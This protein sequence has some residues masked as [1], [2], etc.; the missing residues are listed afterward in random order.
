M[1]T[2]DRKALIARELARV[3]GRPPNPD[4][5]LGKHRKMAANPFRFLRGAAQ[6]FYADLAQGRLVL[7]P[8]LLE[9]PLTFIQGDCHFSNFGFLTEEGS[10]GDTVIWAPN[11][12]DDAAAGHAAFDL[13]RFSVSIHLIGDFCRGV[14]EGRYEVEDAAIHE[15]RPAPQAGDERAAVEAFLAEYRQ[16]CTAMQADSGERDRALSRFPKEHVLRKPGRKA[17]KR[18]AGGPDFAT[19]STVAKNTVLTEDRPRFKNRVDRFRALDLSLTVGVAEAFRPYVDDDIIDVVRRIGAGTGSVNVDRYYLLVGPAGGISERDLRLAHIVEV[20]QQREAALIHHF[21]ALS[22]VNTLSPAHLTVDCQRQMMR[23]P[24]LILDE[25][26][27]NR[28]HWL[29]RSRHHARVSLDPEAL[30][31][32]EAPGEALVQYATACAESLAR[33]HARGDRRSTRFEAA[34]AGAL[35]TSAEALADTAQAYAEQSRHDQKLLRLMLGL[36]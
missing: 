30:L 21:P 8:A 36:D 33:T 6:L 22:P 20:K 14:A 12:F 3:D 7:P 15:G 26:Y 35:E 9:P 25:V 32:R 4:A 24:D 31:A 28:H 17:A 10:H 1:K 2:H 13:L 18:A 27:W 34:M 19:K 5:P 29:V 23:R 16:T 11:D